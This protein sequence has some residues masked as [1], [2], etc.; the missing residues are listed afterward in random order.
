MGKI[1]LALGACFMLLL[2][3]AIT[4]CGGGGDSSTAGGS[5]VAGSEA[6]DGSAAG[7][8]AAERPNGAEE[9]EASGG[10]EPPPVR[11]TSESKEQFV[12]KASRLC[13]R[14]K[15]ELMSGTAKL[16][17]KGASG[18]SPEEAQRDL[19][20]EVIAPAFEAEASELRKLG[21]PRGDQKRVAAIVAEIETMAAGARRNPAAFFAVSPA[22]FRKRNRLAREY[23]IGACGALS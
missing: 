21:A 16:L 15:R 1:L 7:E 22:E 9:G 3:A 14:R 12:A 19:A 23:G 11:P 18:R 4:G 10:G 13:G 2:G 5:S 6:G 17:G 20:Q 8:G